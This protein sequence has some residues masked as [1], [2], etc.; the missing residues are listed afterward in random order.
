MRG[1]WRAYIAVQVGEEGNFRLFDSLDLFSKENLKPPPKKVGG[2]G[3]FLRSF[4]VKILLKKKDHIFNGTCVRICSHHNTQTSAPF[5]CWK[6]LL[7]R[8]LVYLC[9]D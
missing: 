1:K 4:Y 2:D 8:G 9:L 5:P 6:M 7:L 3:V